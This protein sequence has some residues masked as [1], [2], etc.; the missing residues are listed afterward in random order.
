MGV[1]GRWEAGG[2]S[3][4]LNPKAGE[5]G[6]PA[7]VQGQGRTDVSA[8]AEGQFPVPPLPCSGQALKGLDEAHDMDEGTLLSQ[9]TESDANLF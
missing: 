5:P 8:G 9:S 1:E 4:G 2:V 6:A 7:D 3:P